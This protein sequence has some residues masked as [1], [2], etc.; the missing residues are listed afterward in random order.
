MTMTI[1]IAI[2]ETIAISTITTRAM[3]TTMTIS[4][5]GD[6]NPVKTSKV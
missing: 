4:L 2:T 5:I 1:T 6:Q 3:D